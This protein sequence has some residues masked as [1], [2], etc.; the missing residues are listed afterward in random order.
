VSGESTYTTALQLAGGSFTATSRWQ[1]AS[2][3]HGQPALR[4]ALFVFPRLYQSPVSS[5]VVV[6]ECQERGVGSGE[7]CEMP[8]NGCQCDSVRGRELLQLVSDN[9]TFE[10]EVN[11]P[12]L[13]NPSTRLDGRDGRTLTAAYGPRPSRPPSVQWAW[14]AWDGTG[15]AT[16]VRNR[17]AHMVRVWCAYLENRERIWSTRDG[18]KPAS[19]PQNGFFVPQDGAMASVL[20]QFAQR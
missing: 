12:S 4:L 14:W 13:E 18:Q 9:S 7:G 8:A 11:F 15:T 2:L 6:R 19:V 10:E 1:E 16:V 17:P 3:R 5:S 20:L